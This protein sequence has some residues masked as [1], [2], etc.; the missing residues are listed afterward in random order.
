MKLPAPEALEA[1]FLGPLQF[2]SVGGHRLA[3]RWI[4]A[5]NG[6]P[7]AP[8][9]VLTTGYGEQCGPPRSALQALGM[10]GSAGF[11]QKIGCCGA[12]DAKSNVRQA[13][14]LWLPC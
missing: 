2:A 8:P 13:S 5:R 7:H 4:P 1:D 11:S 9:L 14:Q 6:A 3:Y 12:M 10:A